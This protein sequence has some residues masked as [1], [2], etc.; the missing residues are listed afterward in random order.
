M[1]FLRLIVLAVL[2][3][4]LGL[5]VAASSGL[6]ADGAENSEVRAIPV[7]T[8]SR[9]VGEVLA[10]CMYHGARPADFRVVSTSCREGAEQ[11]TAFVALRSE[12]DLTLLAGFDLMNP[13]VEADGPSCDRPAFLRSGVQQQRPEQ[14]RTG[15]E[16]GRQ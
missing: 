16:R 12:G 10:V 6:T 14:H 15:G 5:L 3:A 2:A 8:K 1:A 7:L 13:P 4:G 9:E 11:C